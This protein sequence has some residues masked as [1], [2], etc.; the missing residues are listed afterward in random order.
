MAR[1]TPLVVVCVCNPGLSPT[2][3]MCSWRQRGPQKKEPCHRQKWSAA[4][5]ARSMKGVW[6]VHLVPRAGSITRV[7]K[8]EILV[9]FHQCPQQPSAAPPRLLHLYQYHS[10][11]LT[12][13]LTFGYS[14]EWRAR[15]APWDFHKWLGIGAP[16]WKM[17]PSVSACMNWECT[18]GGYFIQIVNYAAMEFFQ[19]GSVDD[20]FQENYCRIKLQFAWVFLFYVVHV[21]SKHF[22]NSSCFD[23]SMYNLCQQ[24][25]VCLL[26]KSSFAV[27][28][29]SVRPCPAGVLMQYAWQLSKRNFVSFLELSRAFIRCLGEKWRSINLMYTP[30]VLWSAA[31]PGI[32]ERREKKR[33]RDTYEEAT[34]GQVDSTSWTR[35]GALVNR[36]SSSIY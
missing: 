29:C 19:G 10:A 14:G 24:I 11:K 3:H 8:R 2:C 18:W 12:P 33:E 34:R 9:C 17:T 7:R 30:S 31:R 35:L 4:R 22:L 25:F 15:T 21:P 5:P 27:F 28:W 16:M 23:F 36:K 20:A 26:C 6:M 1:R 32:S 13:L